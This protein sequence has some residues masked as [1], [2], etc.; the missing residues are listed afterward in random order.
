MKQKTA[1]VTDSDIERIILRDFARSD[2]K[3]VKIILSNYKTEGAKERNRVYAS[4]LK[5]SAGD[6][7]LLEKYVH[8][9]NVDYRDLIALSEYPNYTER[10][11]DD[12]F[13]GK[14]KAKLIDDDWR[15]YQEWLMK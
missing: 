5:L 14:R 12:D 6:I 1:N 15:Q 7:D 3:T 8:R 10:M 2:L 9:A 4:A 11:L 13:S